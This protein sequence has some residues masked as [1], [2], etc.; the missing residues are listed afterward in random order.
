MLKQYLVTGGI[1]ILAIWL[2]KRTPLNQ[3]LG[4]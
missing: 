2:V 1:A 3:W 4:L